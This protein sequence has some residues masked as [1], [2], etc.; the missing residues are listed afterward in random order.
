MSKEHGRLVTPVEV[1]PGQRFVNQIRRQ[2]GQRNQAVIGLF[3]LAEP[4]LR[5]RQRGPGIGHMTWWK[6]EQKVLLRAFVAN[7]RIFAL[8]QLVQVCHGQQAALVEVFHMRAGLF[9]PQENVVAAQ[10]V[11][12]FT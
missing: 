1:G 3:E 7:G 11:E 2:C 6:H 5:Q 8:F 12:Q 4:V 10:A 9:Q